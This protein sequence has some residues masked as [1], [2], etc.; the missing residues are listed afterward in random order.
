MAEVLWPLP[1]GP[2]AVLVGP[3][4]GFA[5]PERAAL[6][7]HPAVHPAALG[8]RQLRAETAALAALAC[9]QAVLGDWP[10]R[11]SRGSPGYPG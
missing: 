9:W 4:G 11:G 1:A 8:P 5:P 6:L 10:C 7:A 2:W 3:E